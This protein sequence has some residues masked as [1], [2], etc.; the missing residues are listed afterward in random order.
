MATDEILV[1][2]LVLA[3]LGVPAFVSAY[4][5]RR[6]PLTAMLML[7]LGGGCIAWAA[8]TRPGGYVLSEVPEVFFRVLGQFL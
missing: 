3:W 5:N 8:L 1:I 7:L 6:S 2:G 4:A